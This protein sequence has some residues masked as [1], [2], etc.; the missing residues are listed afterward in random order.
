MKSYALFLITSF[1]Y[2]ISGILLISSNQTT[3]GSIFIALG[4]AYFAITLDKRKK[5]KDE[6]K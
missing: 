5:Q 3:W 4:C 1:L 2:Y 6:D